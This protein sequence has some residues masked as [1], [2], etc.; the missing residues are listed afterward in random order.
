MTYY[1]YNATTRTLSPAPNTI[2][3]AQ[4][5]IVILSAARHATRG[6]FPRAADTPPTPPAGKI[7]VPDGYELRDS[8]WHRVYRYEDA[9]P[10]PPRTFSKLRI[11][12]ALMEAGVWD[13]VKQWIVDNNLYD[14]YL[15]AQDFAE[16]NAYF[17]Q[18]KTALQQALGWTDGQVEA[19]LAAAV[20]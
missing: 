10:P 5:R 14:L 1:T 17:V 8:A 3:D 12:A 13:S 4:G 11:V 18:G 6:E 15:A 2:R 7:A 20:I 9:P 16:D 19:V